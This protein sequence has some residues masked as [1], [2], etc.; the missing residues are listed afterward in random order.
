MS[1][2]LL[3]EFRERAVLLVPVPD[4]D[5]LQRRGTARR[6][7]RLAAGAA[8]L[9]SV[10]AIGGTVATT[11]DDEQAI[12]PA[13]IGPTQMDPPPRSA[14]AC[15]LVVNAGAYGS[16]PS[17]C[18]LPA[19]VDQ[20]RYVEPGRY[21]VRPFKTDLRPDRA[22]DLEAWFSISGDYW[23]WWGG[24]VGKARPSGGPEWAPYIRVG[25]TPII[26]V[27]K[28]RCQGAAPDPVQAIPASV[29]SVAENLVA[30]P[31]ITVLESPSSVQ[32]FGYDAAHVQFTVTE[33]CPGDMVFVLWRASEHGADIFAPLGEERVT[34]LPWPPKPQGHV[35]D[36][37]VV[38]VPGEQHLVVSADY[39]VNPPLISGDP[40][41]FRGGARAA[42]LSE[43]WQLLDSIRFEFT[44]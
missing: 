34:G 8:L 10:L 24:G 9:A 4:F 1:E 35:F 23:Y 43:M 7:V 25:V 18:E 40:A 29:I 36:L 38:D 12:E 19:Q 27:H 31:R 2:R 6:R 30:S 42:D 13:Q 28:Q 17:G 26:G 11:I 14:E 16:V 3:T 22:G 33:R 44:E 32:K 21:F 37:W 5:E 41:A 39:T 15:D 20:W